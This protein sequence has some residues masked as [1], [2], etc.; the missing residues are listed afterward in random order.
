M[1]AT[2]HP[3]TPPASALV[4][5]EYSRF[6]P[7]A[8]G[9]GYGIVC[10]VAGLPMT[11]RGYGCLHCVD[12]EG[13]RWTMLTEDVAYVDL[14]ASA[15]GELIRGMPIPDGKFTRRRAGWPDEWV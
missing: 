4:V 8:L 9:D 6:T 15:A 5:K 13:L 1:P 2:N 7:E 12:A 3:S 11:E 10:E 14:L